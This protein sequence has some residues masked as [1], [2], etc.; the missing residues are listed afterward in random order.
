MLECFIVI[1]KSG[2]RGYACHYRFVVVWI[3]NLRLNGDFRMSRKTRDNREEQR[4][5]DG[6]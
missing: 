6:E 4:Q 3:W 2:G 5:Q 1:S